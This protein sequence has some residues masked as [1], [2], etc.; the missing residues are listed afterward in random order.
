MNPT[1]VILQKSQKLLLTAGFLFAT[2]SAGFGA[3]V[4]QDDFNT[5]AV[6]TGATL[7]PGGSWG[8][9]GTTPTE[10][11]GN[12]VLYTGTGASQYKNSVLFTTVASPSLNIFTQTVNIAVRGISLTG[13]GDG[14]APNSRFR[15]GLTA[16][17]AEAYADTS[18]AGN[19]FGAFYSG[20]NDGISLN[21]STA[22]NGFNSFEL[23]YK[24]NSTVPSDPSTTTG[25]LAS[26][27]AFSG[28]IG[29]S[30]IDLDLNLSATTWEVIFYGASGAT[31]VNRGTWS[32][33]GFASTW[34]NATDGFGNSSFL[35]DVQTVGGIAVS[36]PVD[37]INGSATAL[38]NSVT[39]TSVPEPS[40]ALLLTLGIAFLSFGRRA[41]G[42]I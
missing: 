19:T 14:T 11:G 17:S 33:A 36:A 20:G 30:V 5:G 25:M 1:P 42:R 34:G 23:R 13:D 7:L 28:A 12:L 29:F 37:T 16:R 35:M 31:S 26:V 32:L 10:T 38:I 39:V 18:L 40:R 8:T 27:G 15:V 24:A 21:L 2:L 9:T 4:I 22:T 3:T 6:T 41:R